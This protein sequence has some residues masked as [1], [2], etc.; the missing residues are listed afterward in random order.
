[1]TNAPKAGFILL[2]KTGGG[3]Q[4][5]SAKHTLTDYLANGWWVDP[6]SL[7]DAFTGI[8]VFGDVGA[9]KTSGKDPKT[10]KTENAYVCGGGDDE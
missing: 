2:G 4:S 6:S 10:S 8:C 1:M 9:G 5:K 7:R 3:K